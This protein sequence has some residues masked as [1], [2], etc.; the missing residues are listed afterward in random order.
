MVIGRREVLFWCALAV[1]LLMANVLRTGGPGFMND[2]YQY[3]STAENINAGHGLST[4]IV[5]FDVERRSH[6]VPAPLTTFP[7]GYAVA[8]AQVNRTGLDPERAGLL[9]SMLSFV[10][11]F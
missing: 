8:I 5:N 9:F 7:P 11:L 10:A 3:L 2:S 6:K 4:S 1:A